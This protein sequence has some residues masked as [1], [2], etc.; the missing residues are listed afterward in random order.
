MLYH[1][2]ENSPKDARLAR[3]FSMGAWKV[4]RLWDYLL[5]DCGYLGGPATAEA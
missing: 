4:S 1:W 2:T 3:V 5:L